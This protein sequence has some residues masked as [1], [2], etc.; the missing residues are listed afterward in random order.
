MYLFQTH[1]LYT[2]DF[3]DIVCLTKSPKSWRKIKGNEN[4][5]K[6]KKDIPSM[7][8]CYPS[9]SHNFFLFLVQLSRVFN[10]KYKQT[11]IY[12]LLFLLLHKKDILYSKLFHL[13]LSQNYISGGFSIS[14][15][16]EP[17]HF[18]SNNYMLHSLFK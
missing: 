4:K 15:Y 10:Y 18:F 1:T 8:F 12:I 9:H 3:Y 11:Q 14:V 7:F 6:G 17:P 2:S 16:K 13:V 5:W